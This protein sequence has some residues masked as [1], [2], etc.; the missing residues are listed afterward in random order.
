MFSNPVSSSWPAHIQDISICVT[1][2][3]PFS[4]PSSPS[5]N[6]ISVSLAPNNLDT[7]TY[8]ST[9]AHIKLWKVEL[10]FCISQ[11]TAAEPPCCFVCPA[12]RMFC[13][14]I[15]LQWGLDCMPWSFKPACYLSDRFE[16]VC[17]SLLWSDM[18]NKWNADGESALIAT[19]PLCLC[20]CGILKRGN[21]YSLSLSLS[22]CV[23][24]QSHPDKMLCR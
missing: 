1:V 8:A 17:G 22:V 5:E 10:F 13:G 14:N 6:A 16:S 9:N 11:E 15:H 24:M 2:W 20:T 19:K 18:L 7:H 23:L 12:S 3:S 4:F 21:I